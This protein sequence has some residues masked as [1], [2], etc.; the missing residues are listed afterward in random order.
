LVIGKNSTALDGIRLGKQYLYFKV[1]NF[2]AICP[3]GWTLLDIFIFGQG[4][5]C[6]LGRSAAAMT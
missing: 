4:L 6:H 5:H 2:P 3:F 1:E